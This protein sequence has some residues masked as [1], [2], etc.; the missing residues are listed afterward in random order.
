MEGKPRHFEKYQDF[1]NNR[2]LYNKRNNLENA[3]KTE[4][5][6]KINIKNTK[7]INDTESGCLSSLRNQLDSKGKNKINENNIE[8]NYNTYYTSDSQSKNNNILNN[9]F[10]NINFLRDNINL[11]NNQKITNDYKN[12][13]DN[14]YND[15]INKISKDKIKIKNRAFSANYLTKN[16]EKKDL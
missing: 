15:K 6:F 7:K 9:T 10:N 13:G 4:P 5:S 2:K 16:N 11:N 12:K 8:T 1:L 14:E 3:N